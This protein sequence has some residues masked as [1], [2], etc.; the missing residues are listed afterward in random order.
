MS[1]DAPE[2]EFVPL[3]AAHLDAVMAIEQE[4][5]PDAWSRGMF[6]DEMR[7]PLS[8]FYVVVSEKTII[9]YGG[10]WLILDEAHITS[11]TVRR[12]ERGR[13]LGRGILRRLLDAA[14]EQG[15]RRVTLEVR[16]SNTTARRLYV[17]EGFEEVG[18]RRKY[19]PKSG[20]DAVVM[21]R[22]LA[23]PD[24]QTG[25]AAATPPEDRRRE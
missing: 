11:V 21:A 22:T 8:V 18:R 19:Y 25:G 7:N 14:T 5:Y 3:R 16:E 20:E 9:G 10:F 15:A 24:G 12:E 6:E 13:G 4:A 1:T 23:A 17:S 2:V